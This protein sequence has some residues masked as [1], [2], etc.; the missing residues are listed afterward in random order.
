MQKFLPLGGAG[1]IGANCY[2][3]N[4]NGIG[5]I[6]DCGMHPQKSGLDSLPKFDLLENQPTD[7]VL[8]SHAHQDHLNALPF[9]IKKFPHLKII[10]SPQ[11]RAVAELTLHNAISLLKRQ[12]DEREFEIYSRAEVDLLIKSINYKSCNEKFILTSLNS[13]SEIEAEFFDAGHIIGS[14][15]VMLGFDGT[16]IFFTGDINLSSQ[17]LLNGAILPSEKIDA[18]ITETTYGATDSSSLHTWEKEAERFSSSINKIINRGGSVL[19]PVFALGKLQEMLA[20]IWLLMQSNKI[21]GVDIY[22]GGI[23]NKISMIYDYNRYVVNRNEK[24]TVL[25][26][27]PQKNLNELKD[28]EELFKVPCIVLASSGMMVEGTNSFLLAK[29][30]LQKKDSAIFTV[31]YMD[32]LTPGYIVSNA[33]KGDRIQLTERDRKVEVKCEIKN[34]RFSAHSKR[35]ELISLAGKLNPEKIVLIHGDKE[36]IDWLGASMLKQFPGKKI[37]AAVNYKPILF[38]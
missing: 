4:I 38:D 18:L 32:P 14:V 34:F 2:Y 31:G 11:T 29:R 8:I 33:R 19:I 5:I 22:T 16:K 15:G 20:T 24:E 27:I 30:W 36:A 23:G 9:L 26:D 25:Y 12:V 13:T 3:I 28:H 10:T 37:F 7:Y 21:T 17:T 35:E 6:L 1:E